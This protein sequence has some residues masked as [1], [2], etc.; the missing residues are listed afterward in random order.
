MRY[1]NPENSAYPLIGEYLEVA[2]QLDIKTI[3]S[4]PN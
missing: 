4:D 1:I 2:K 3:S